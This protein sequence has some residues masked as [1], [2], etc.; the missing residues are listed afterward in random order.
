MRKTL[1]L[2]KKVLKPS[3]T[4]TYLPIFL[5]NDKNMIEKLPLW[6]KIFL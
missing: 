6:R 2:K 3:Y 5:R 1:S 4:P